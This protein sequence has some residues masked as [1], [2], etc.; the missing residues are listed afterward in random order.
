MMLCSYHASH[1]QFPPS[2]LLVLAARAEAAGFD[3]VFCSDHLQPWAPSQAHAGHAWVWL[4]AALQATR[5]ASFATITVP[6]GWRYHPVPLAQAIGTL[7][8]MFPGR[9]PWIA[10]GSGEAVNEHV[11]GAGWPPKAERNT[12][13]REGVEVVRA[14][15]AGERVRHAGHLRVEDARIWDRG[16]TPP[17][18]FGAATCEETARWLGGWADGLL[19]LGRDLGQLERV[20]DAFRDGGGAGK[21]V[22]VK[23]D[24]AW[25]PDDG[26]ALQEAHR[27]WRF[28]ALGSEVNA[29]LRQ[30]EDFVAATRFVRPG[31]M[32]AH[33]LV[34]SD[35]GRHLAHLEACRALGVDGVDVHHVGLSQ[36]AFIDAFGRDVLPALRK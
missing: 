24:V 10:F 28:N 18:L 9:V 33:V 12:R 13:L 3:G 29:V 26:Q 25:G 16:G 14:L 8:Q 30:P 1:E 11:V 7:A 20:I 2:E 35:A 17:R 27:H 22:H 19:T 36:E 4:G 32:H 15:L 6:G 5:R 21:P 31:D 23:V 34:S